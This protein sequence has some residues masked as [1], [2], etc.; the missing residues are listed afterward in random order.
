VTKNF[1][2]L[3][4]TFSSP[5]H[6]NKHSCSRESETILGNAQGKLQPTPTDAADHKQYNTTTQ[7]KTFLHLTT[8]LASS[9]QKTKDA[10]LN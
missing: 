8:T 7:S 9:F 2:R 3:T 6:K 1:H 4:T 10:Q 5:I